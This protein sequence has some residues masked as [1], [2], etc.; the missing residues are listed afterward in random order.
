MMYYHN[1][2]QKSMGFDDT[3]IVAVKRHEHRINFQFVTKNNTVAR[4]KNSDLSEKSE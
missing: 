1:T 2:T 4:M 3:V